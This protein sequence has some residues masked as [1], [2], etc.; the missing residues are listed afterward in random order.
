MIINIKDLKKKIIYRSSYRGSKEM[1]ELLSAFVK[2]YINDLDE[3]AL[4]QLSDLMDLDDE[5]LYLFKQGQSTSAQ[6][7]EN[8]ITKL[9]KNFTFTEE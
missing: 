5:N 6:I 2:K 4:L 9:F 7:Q 1:D 3:S 8:K